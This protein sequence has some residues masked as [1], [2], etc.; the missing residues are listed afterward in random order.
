MNSINDIKVAFV[1]L[2]GTLIKGQSQALFIKFLK[3]KKIIS[4]HQSF[5]ILSWFFLYKIGLAKKTEKILS[6]ALSCFKNRP[7]KDFYIYVNEFIESVIKA[8]YYKDAGLFLDDMRSRNIKLVILSTSVDIL[9]NKI[10]ENLRIESYLATKVEISNGIF[11]GRIIG[12]QNYGEKKLS[13]ILEYIKRDNIELKNIL[14]VADNYSDKEIL[15]QAGVGIVANP[16]KNMMNW[17]LQNK[18]H[19]IYLDRYEPIQYI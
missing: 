19:M 1:D 10:S 4:N 3:N 6:Y 9:V 17:A 18:L 13:R 7:V 11:T 16:D 15:I 12:E 2:D 5:I 8:N 14:V